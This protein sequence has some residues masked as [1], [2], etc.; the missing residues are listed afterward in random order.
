M[1]LTKIC[2]TSANRRGAVRA[3]QSRIIAAISRRLQTEEIMP[4]EVQQ[5]L[6]IHMEGPPVTSSDSSA[7][8]QVSYFIG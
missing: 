4:T 1:N 6:V 8:P 3:F 7:S 2:H 5:F